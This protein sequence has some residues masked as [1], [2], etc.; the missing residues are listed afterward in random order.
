MSSRLKILLIISPTASVYGNYKKLY[1]R[2]FLNPPIHLCYLASAIEKAGHEV[3]IVD[4]DAELLNITEVVALAGDYRPDLIGITATSIDF[5]IAETIVRLLKIKY[6]EIPIIIGGTHCNIFRKRVLDSNPAIDFAC[7][8]DGEDLIVELLD[9]LQD[10]DEKSLGL[11]KGLIYRRNGTV[12]QNPDRKIKKDIDVYP[13]PARHHLK[14]ELYYRAVPH[15]GYKTTTAFMSSR[16]CPY[17]C[18]YCAVKNITGGKVVRLRSSENVV[19]ELDYI[20]NKMKITHISFNDDCLTLSKKRIYEICEGIRRR[21]LKFTW[22]G[23][24]RADLVDKLLLKTMRDA[25]FIRISYG[26]ESGNPEILKVLNKSE[27]LEQIE[28]A[29][30]I[31]SEIGIVTRGSVIIGSP[32]E[33]RQKVKETFR[34]IRKIKGLDQVVINIMQPYPGTKV[35]DMFLNGKGGTRYLCNPDDLNRLQRFGSA[36]ISVNDLSSRD[37]VFFQKLGFLMF[38]LRPKTMINNL[39][40]SGWDVFFQ[41]GASFI[42][43][44]FGI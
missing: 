31:T 25:G 27:T 43:S 39:R 17:N 42:R 22:E 11:I 37:L 18:I 16:G 30:R 1:K 35:R 8:G 20:V 44:V 21:G 32:Y 5:E 41:D 12:V 23:L 40:I 28:E 2:G 26:I 15:Q 7:I 14:N 36:S 6:P 29:F 19:E 24:S 4:G 10:K 33:T 38:Y 3:R 34:F 13:F 9:A